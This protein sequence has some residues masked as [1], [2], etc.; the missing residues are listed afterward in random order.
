MAQCKK[1]VLKACVRQDG[2]R[3]VVTAHAIDELNAG[4]VLRAA[5]AV[6]AFGPG[7]EAPGDVDDGIALTLLP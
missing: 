2:A 3:V 1:S 4:V 7:V 5:M 6:M